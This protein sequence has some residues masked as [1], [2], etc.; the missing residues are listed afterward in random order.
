MKVSNGRSFPLIGTNI[1]ARR[2][3]G[4]RFFSPPDFVEREPWERG[5]AQIFARDIAPRRAS[6]ERLRRA[7]SEGASPGVCGG[8]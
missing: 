8:V 3:A 4:F 1:R 5:F 7:A 2:M 6:L